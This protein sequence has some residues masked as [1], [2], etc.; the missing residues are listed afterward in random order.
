[1]AGKTKTNVERLKEKIDNVN[2]PSHYQ[3]KDG[4]E[5]MDL[6]EEATGEFSGFDSFCVGNIFK[7]VMRNGK[8]NG[9][10]DL[11][12]ARYYLDTMISRHKEQQA[13]PKDKKQSDDSW[14]GKKVTVRLHKVKAPWE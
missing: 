1:M 14:D 12:K 5:V 11:E 9:I 6:I 10:E 2:H 7:Y 3:L 8:K 4:R 13:E